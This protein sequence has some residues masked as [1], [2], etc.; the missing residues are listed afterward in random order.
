MDHHCTSAVPSPCQQCTTPMLSQDHPLTITA[1]A[2]T[3]THPLDPSP[4]LS[5]PQQQRSMVL[6]WQRG[7]RERSQR[8][9]HTGRDHRQR[10]AG[11]KQI[12]SGTNKH[13]QAH[14]STHKHKQ[15]QTSTQQHTQSHAH[16]HTGSPHRRIHIPPYI[17]LYLPS[18]PPIPSLHLEFSPSPVAACS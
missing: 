8:R 1:S 6:E 17:S 11:I 3:R 15:A 12:Q 10:T 18:N 5:A 16:R 2:H 14:N 9:P 4:C 13:K 7:A